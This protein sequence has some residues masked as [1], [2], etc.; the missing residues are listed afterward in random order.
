MREN[1]GWFSLIGRPASPAGIGNERGG[2]L[3]TQ[4]DMIFDC[5]VYLFQRVPFIPPDF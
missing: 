1:P 2:A 5:C 3:F 4:T